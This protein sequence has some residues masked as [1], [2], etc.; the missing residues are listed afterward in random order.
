MRALAPQVSGHV[1][2]DG[3]EIGYEVFGDGDTTVLLMP[4]WTIIHSRFWK[5]QVPYLARFFRVITYDGPGNGRSPQSTDPADYS[6][7][8]QVGYARAVLDECQTDRVVAVG[9]SQGG[10]YVLALADAQP[11]RVAALA[12]IAPALPLAPPPSDRAGIANTF[13]KPYEEPVEGW[14]RYNAAYWLDHYENFVPF[15]M[16]EVFSETHATKQ[17][18]DAVRWAHETSGEVLVAEAHSDDEVDYARVLEEV[19]CPVLFIHGTEDR[20]IT[21]AV[22]EEGARLSSGAL[23]TLVGSGHGPHLKEPVKVNLA[24]RDFIERNR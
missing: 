10:R 23:L 20:I 2:C 3:L 18:D 16:G 19:G 12:L 6:M 17:W 13:D 22:S 7:S 1:D 21:H 14:S 15:F 11:D 4:T 5:L 24:L 8:A 9:F